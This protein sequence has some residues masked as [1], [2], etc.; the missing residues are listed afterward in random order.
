MSVHVEKDV[1]GL[2]GEVGV[3]VKNK[4]GYGILFHPWS[5]PDWFNGTADNRVYVSL[6]VLTKKG[7]VKKFSKKLKKDGF[8]KDQLDFADIFDREEFVEG[9]I[10][11]FPELQRRE[12]T[13]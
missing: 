4:G 6:G 9:L 8:Y 2:A 13:V 3:T 1:Y 7:R 10:Q 12:V 11:A 5:R